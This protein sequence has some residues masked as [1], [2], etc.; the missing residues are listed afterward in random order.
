M[1][2]V[3]PQKKIVQTDISDDDLCSDNFELSP[4]LTIPSMVPKF[5][6]SKFTFPVSTK[7]SLVDHSKGVIPTNNQDEISGDL[8]AIYKVSKNRSSTYIDFDPTS[9]TSPYRFATDNT[10]TGVSS[11]KKNFYLGDNLNLKNGVG[12]HPIKEDLIL[13]DSDLDRPIVLQD[14][15]KLTMVFNSHFLDK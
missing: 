10:H 14:G 1:N 8:K 15:S 9:F 11:I 7:K 3:P 13:S 2:R 5:L 12:H 4:S 6:S